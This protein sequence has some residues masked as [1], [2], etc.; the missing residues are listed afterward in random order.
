M[1]SRR[2][3]SRAV[4]RVRGGSDRERWNGFFKRMLE[5]GILLPPSPFEAWFLSTAHDAAVVDRVV[6][7]ARASF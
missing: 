4:T 5:Q 7:A 3:V 1:A 2:E 6:E